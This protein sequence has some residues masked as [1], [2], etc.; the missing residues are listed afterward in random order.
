MLTLEQTK[1]ILILVRSIRKRRTDTK[2]TTES[3]PT[4]SETPSKPK[5]PVESIDLPTDT[6][7]FSETRDTPFPVP[8]PSDDTDCEPYSEHSEVT[9]LPPS[10]GS[11]AS[12][13]PTTPGSP[14]PDRNLSPIPTM[15]TVKDL[16]EAL[17]DNLNDIGRHPTIPLPQFRG[18]REKIQ[19]IIVGKL[20]NI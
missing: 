5:S 2:S 15:G 4:T 20:R 3:E 1:Y 8:P 19:M 10:P 17:T 13:D 6:P 7:L 9:T 18:K 11:P 12:P 16:A 14:S